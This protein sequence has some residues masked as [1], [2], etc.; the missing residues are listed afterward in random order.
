MEKMRL[1]PYPRSMETLL[2][3][4]FFIGVWTAI[5]YGIALTAGW[6]VLA[7]HYLHKSDFQGERFRFKSGY[8]GK[9][10]YGGTLMLGTS[11]LGFYLATFWMFRCGHPALLIPWEDIT[12]NLKKQ[13]IISTVQFEFSK[14]P[15][16]SLNLPKGLA[17]KIAKASGSRLNISQS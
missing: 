9:A 11:P 6:N 3:S 14:T 16:I 1:T 5:S 4:F 12:V 17:K 10:S 15:G 7:D 8:I 13:W 2:K